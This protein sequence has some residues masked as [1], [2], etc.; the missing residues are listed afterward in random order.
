MPHFNK[1]RRT[2]FTNPRT[3]AAI[4]AEPNDATWIDGIR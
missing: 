1:G 2:V 4:R 3:S